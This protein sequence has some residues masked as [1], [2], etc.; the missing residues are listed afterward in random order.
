MSNST[1]ALKHAEH[2]QASLEPLVIHL[3]SLSHSGYKFRFEELNIQWWIH[4]ITIGR[5]L[6][7]LF[8]QA[9]S[10]LDVYFSQNILSVTPQ[11]DPPLRIRY[12]VTFIH[13]LPEEEM[14]VAERAL[15]EVYGAL[16]RRA[17]LEI[18]WK[19]WRKA[20]WVDPFDLWRAP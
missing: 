13:E 4:E 3:S 20:H 18:E 10:S 15:M 8:L 2:F 12:R 16:H 7:H 6:H 17:A 19:Q 1:S 14:I 9:C 11:R 5:P